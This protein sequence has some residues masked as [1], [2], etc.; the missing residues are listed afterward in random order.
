MSKENIIVGIDVGSSATRAIIAQEVSGAEIPRIIGVGIVPSFGMRK[1]VIVD[2]EEVVKV[3]N[4]A[5]E[6]CER[7]AGVTAR[8]A[9][10]SIGGPE[11]NFQN[12]KGVIAIGRADGEVTEEDLNRVLTEAQAIPVPLNKEII[13]IIPQNYRLD[14][15]ENI[16]DPLGMKGVR[17]EVNALIIEASSLYI[18]NLTKCVNQAGIEAEELILAPL[19][20]AKSVIT[21]KQKELGSVLINIGGGT[22]SLAVFEE[23]DLIHTAILPIG[24]GHITNDIAIGLRTSIDVAEKVKLEY[25]SAIADEINKKE[26]I[27]LSQFDSQEVGTVL[28]HH[29]AEIIEARL[30]EIFMMANKELKLI[31]KAGL[32]PAGAILTGGGAKMP[33]IVDLAKSILGL[34]SQ[35][36]FPVNLGGMMD[37]V[38]DPSFATAVGLILWARERMMINK[39]GIFDNISIG[40]GGTV[41]KMKGWIGKFLP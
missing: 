4:E 24:A 21:K 3:I 7:M 35:I 23:G 22:T 27:D 14:D 28:R 6:T 39:K 16:K 38:D 9:I 33:Q 8:E 18:K 13:H 2:M 41:K 20:S 40:A 17:L 1:G 36:G 30:E 12:S 34:P 10:V 31:G 37:K 32:L 19:A 25:G 11:I 29:V 15:Q 26:E 5:V